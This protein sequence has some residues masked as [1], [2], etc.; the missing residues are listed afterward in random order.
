MGFYFTFHLF[1]DID[2]CGSSPCLNG[3]ICNNLVN[4]YTCSCVFGY[5]GTRCETGKRQTRCSLLITTSMRSLLSLLMGRQWSPRFCHSWGEGILIHR[6][7]LLYYVPLGHGRWSAVE[8]GGCGLGAWH[9][10]NSKATVGRRLIWFLVTVIS[11]IEAQCLYF[12]NYPWYVPLLPHVPL[13]PRVPLF[14]Q[15]CSENIT[16]DEFYRVYQFEDRR[17]KI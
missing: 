4:K 5:N 15:P 10:V 16:S 6:S 1:L 8:I 3:A 7:W 13:F 12:F 2:E 17:P 14:F 9:G 11:E